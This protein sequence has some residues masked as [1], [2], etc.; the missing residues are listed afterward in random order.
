MTNGKRYPS[1]Q[2]NLVQS[3]DCEA[4]TFPGGTIMFFRGLL[5]LGGSEAAVA[6]IVGHELRAW[7]AATC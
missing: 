3:S 2:V 4:R 5:E 6:G 1:I 7:T